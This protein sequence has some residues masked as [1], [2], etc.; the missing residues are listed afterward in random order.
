MGTLIIAVAAALLLDRWFGEPRRFHPLAGFGLWAGWLERRLNRNGSVR[1]G[2]LACLLAVGP[3]VG[4]VAALQGFLA[5]DS[6]ARLGLDVLVLTGVLGWRSMQ[7]HARAV[8]VP[9]AAGDLPAARKAL[10][11]IVSRDSETLSER[12]VAGSAIESIFENTNDALIASLFWYVLLGPAGALAHR[13]INTLDAMWG[14]RNARFEHF[15]RIAARLDD[16]LGW[17]PARLTALSFM[18]CGRCLAGWRCWRRQAP[19]HRSPNAGVVIAAGAGA[20]GVVVG[21]AV[22]YDGERRPKPPLG[23]GRRP[24]AADINAALAL[25]DSVLWLW[26]GLFAAAYWILKFGGFAD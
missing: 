3:P 2:G 5:A 15:G 1:A 25:V 4:L 20:L 6:L 8:A 18:L 13:L 23:A 9:L 26:I 17:P 11:R 14:Y 19:R 12:R 10:S 21:G 16:W 7:Q 24:Q 22:S